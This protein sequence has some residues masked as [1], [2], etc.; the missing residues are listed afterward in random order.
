MLV[1][2][3][4]GIYEGRCWDVIRWND[5]RTKSH[6]HWCRR[7]E[8]IMVLP[9]RN[10][11]IQIKRETSEHNVTRQFPLRSTVMCICIRFVLLFD[12]F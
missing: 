2:L 8:N 4:S 6:E 9:K 5:K 3:T 7:S 12:N 1:L 11:H 10:K